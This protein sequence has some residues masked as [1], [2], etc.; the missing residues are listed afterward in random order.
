MK[1]L[2]HHVT[3]DRAADQ[4]RADQVHSGIQ[5]NRAQRQCQVA[6]FVGNQFQQ[7]SER[8]QRRGFLPLF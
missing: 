6:A 8:F 5:R 3:V 2:R 1:L 4:V 7:L